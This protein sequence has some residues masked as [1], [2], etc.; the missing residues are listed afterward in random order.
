MSGRFLLKVFRLL[1]QGVRES[2]F[3]GAVA[4]VIWQEKRYIIARG[5]RALTPFFEPIEEYDIFD[6]ASLTKPLALAFSYMHVLEKGSTDLSLTAS[7]GE[8]LEIKC[9]LSKISIYRFLN[10]T[11]GLRSWYP[12]YQELIKQEFIN[13]DPAH[14]LE[15]VIKRIEQLPLEYKPGERSL[16]SDLGYFLLTYLIE[17][18][19][20]KS[21][22]EI[23]KEVKERINFKAR[24]FLD[25]KPL[26]KGIDQEILVPTSVCPWE[27]KLLRGI[28]EDENTRAL[29][30]VSGVAGLFG[31]IQG[32]LDILEFFLE[33][34][35]QNSSFSEIM[36]TFINFR[37]RLSDF[38]LGFMLLNSREREW[39]KNKISENTV[40]HTGF[41]GTAF[42][43]DFENHLAIVL[44]TNRVH[45]DRENIKIRE[46]RP[47]FYKEVIEA[48]YPPKVI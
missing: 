21:F 36:K 14:R 30:G 28:V 4:G 33:C 41:T 3:P 26:K 16:Y 19:L 38:V 35:H 43:I 34:Y 2:V 12:F 42:M 44:L 46:F 15:Y 8:Y 48:L 7:L 18:K 17:Q 47:Y 32:V 27:R 10:H 6:L 39:L 9:P 40:K 37:E 45:P 1:D 23:F 25:F 24:S 11:S 5:Y 29:G 22:E 13:T 31:N 20:G